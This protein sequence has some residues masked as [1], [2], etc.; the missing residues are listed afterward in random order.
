MVTFSSTW[1]WDRTSYSLF[2]SR[3]H[4]LESCFPTTLDYMIIEKAFYRLQS[5]QILLALYMRTN[6]RK[7]GCHLQFI[8]WTEKFSIGS[9]AKPKLSELNPQIWSSLSLS[10]W[11]KEKK[12]KNNVN[13]LCN[14]LFRWRL[15][16]STWN[17]RNSN[18]HVSIER[19]TDTFNSI[20]FTK[21]YNATTKPN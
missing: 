20:L 18:L 2:I 21:C 9:I 5:L 19:C 11:W 6:N 15:Y 12:H 3:S 17:L 13:L 8:Y 14:W 4:W 16:T 7:F 1:K 10:L